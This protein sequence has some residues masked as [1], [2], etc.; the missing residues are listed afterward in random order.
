MTIEFWLL[1]L[2]GTFL[3]WR[4]LSWLLKCLIVRWAWR[5]ASPGAKCVYN[6]RMY[7]AHLTP[8]QRILAKEPWPQ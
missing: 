6:R 7:L 4:L 8:E 1:G 5:V 3:L 2:G